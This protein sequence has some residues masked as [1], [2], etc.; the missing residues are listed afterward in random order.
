MYKEI[1]LILIEFFFIA[2]MIALI[3][4]VEYLQQSRKSQNKNLDFQQTTSG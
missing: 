2:L 3:K 1:Y 4:T